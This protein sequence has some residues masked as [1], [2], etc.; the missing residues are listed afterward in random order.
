MLLQI[1][2][3]IIKSVF[4]FL[5]PLRCNTRYTPY[6]KDGGGN[7]VYLDRH[8]VWCGQNKMILSMGLVRNRSHKNYRYKYKCYTTPYPCY[9]RFVSNPFTY[10]GRGSAVYLDRQNVQCSNDDLITYF[11]L[12]R[13]PTH[14]KVHYTYKCC[15][16]P[17]RQ[18]KSYDASTPW[19][20]E[21][22]G[23]AVYLDRHHVHWKLGYGLTKFQLVR[24]G[25]GRYRYSIRCT[26]IIV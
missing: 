25:H 6:N 1:Q 18:K 7:F 2:I 24:N 3:I 15:N 8:Q 22:R 26:K 10:D 4:L 17:D 16:I 12:N 5:V 14:N 13:N 20:L 9:Q 11:H 23:N 19:N 21:G